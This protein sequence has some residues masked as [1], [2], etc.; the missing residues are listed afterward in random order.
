MRAKTVL[1]FEYFCVEGALM[2]GNSDGEEGIRK[3]GRKGKKE[4]KGHTFHRRKTQLPCDF[5]VADFTRVCERHAA[6]LKPH[7]KSAPRQSIHHN[8]HP[9]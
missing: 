4:G 7:H 5:R 9:R 3:G 1:A 6:Y 8:P 2:G